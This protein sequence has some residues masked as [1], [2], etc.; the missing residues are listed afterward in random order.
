MAE[1]KFSTEQEQT[2]NYPDIDAALAALPALVAANPSVSL[3]TLVAGSS[4][5]QF[6]KLQ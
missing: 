6:I 1:I 2:Q 3:F 5:W 4:V